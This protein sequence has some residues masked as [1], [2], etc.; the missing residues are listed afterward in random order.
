MSASLMWTNLLP[1]APSSWR[2]CSRSASPL[3]L[4]IHQPRHNS[5]TSGFCSPQPATTGASAVAEAGGVVTEAAAVPNLSGAPAANQSPVRPDSL[6][7]VG[8]AVA[9]RARW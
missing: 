7:E 2:W 1:T 6:E 3:L 5:S 9:G 4:R 8:L